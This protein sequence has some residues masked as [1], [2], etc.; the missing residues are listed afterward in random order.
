ML[1]RPLR[2]LEI[3]VDFGPEVPLRFTPGSMLSPARQAA[4]RSQVGRLD[5]EGHALELLCNGFHLPSIRSWLARIRSWLAI[6]VSS[7]S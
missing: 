4:Q 5:P 2:G 3:D 1:C 7:F 6:T